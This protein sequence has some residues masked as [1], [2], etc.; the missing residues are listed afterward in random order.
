MEER[1]TTPVVRGL[2]KMYSWLL[3]LVVLMA[4]GGRGSKRQRSSAKRPVEQQPEDEGSEYAPGDESREEEPDWEAFTPEVITKEKDK[5]KGKGKAVDKGKG[6]AMEKGKGKAS[7]YTGRRKSGGVEIRE[8]GSEPPRL[9]LQDVPSARR[10]MYSSKH[11]IG[12][13]DVGIASI[14]ECV[15][16]F[17]D[18]FEKGNLHQICDFSEQTGFCLELIR[19][20][21]MR[22]GRLSD[23]GGGPYVFTTSVRGVEL[24][25]TPDT[26]A[27]VL[28]MEAR[29]EGVE[30]LQARFDSLRDWNRVV[31]SI[32][33]SGTE[34]NG[35]MV[36]SKDFKMEY[37]FLNFVVCYNILPL[38]NTKIL[39]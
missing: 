24:S 10:S 33:M 36:L 34:S 35:I 20:F 39:R 18:L 13:H 8:P 3:V 4:G 32:C 11:C 14:I 19:E 37:R 26:I 16:G 22:A 15:P 29:T 25:I 12:E 38:A 30:Y 31:N 27:S 9:S 17:Q 5:R 1:A 23:S 6:K 7:E 21:Y 2:F 28:G